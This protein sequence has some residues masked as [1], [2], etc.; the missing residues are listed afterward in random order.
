MTSEPKT[1][2]RVEF[3]SPAYGSWCR[4]ESVHESRDSA[5]S[6]A[7]LIEKKYADKTR[8]IRIETTETVE[9]ER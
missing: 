1:T 8:I 5:D 4:C 6:H 9:E 2:W 7:K 3:V